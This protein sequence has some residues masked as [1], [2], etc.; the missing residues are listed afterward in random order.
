MTL[1]T[2]YDQLAA[3]PQRLVDDQT[4]HPRGADLPAPPQGYEVYFKSDPDAKTQPSRWQPSLCAAK[5][6]RQAAKKGKPLLFLQGPRSDP[7]LAPVSRQGC[8]TV[9]AIIDSGAED[10]VTPPNLMGTKVVPS[11]M[12]A[13]GQSYRAANGAA[14][15]NY[16]QTTVEFRDNSRKKCGMHFQVADVE[17]P[18]VS[19]AKLVDGGNSVVFTPAGGYIQSLT[20][21]RRIQLVRDGNVYVLDMQ[22]PHQQEEEEETNCATTLNKDSG[23]ARLER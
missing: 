2:E 22:L 12:S 13:S 10:T 5:R 3:G 11:A 16:G 8:R 14:I 15:R 7:R 23:F 18:L 6:A 1:N 21:Q 4:L 19:V 9:R 20:T 17:K